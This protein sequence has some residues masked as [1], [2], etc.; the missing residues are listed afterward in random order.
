M[1]GIVVLK[2]CN[3]AGQKALREVLEVAAVMGAFE[4]LILRVVSVGQYWCGVVMFLTH[5]SLKW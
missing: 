3:Y 2:V 5:D 1:R 4:G